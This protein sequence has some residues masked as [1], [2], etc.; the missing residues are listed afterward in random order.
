MDRS[1]PPSLHLSRP[2]LSS[3]FR[4][5]RSLA[6]LTS[7]FFRREPTEGRGRWP[8]GEESERSD[9]RWV[10][11]AGERHERTAVPPLHPRAL[12]PDHL[13]PARVFRSLRSLHPLASRRRPEGL[14]PEGSARPAARVEWV[15]RIERRGER[16]ASTFHSFLPSLTKR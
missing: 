11:T 7:L 14:R 15:G 5:H 6:T 9:E 8:E 2:S 3:P 10:W 13:L 4:H 16:H 12:S 1:V